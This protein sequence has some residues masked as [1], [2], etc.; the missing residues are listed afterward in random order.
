MSISGLLTTHPEFLTWMYLGPF[1]ANAIAQ[2][3][4]LATSGYILASSMVIAIRVK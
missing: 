2:P 1:L 4:L 3:Y